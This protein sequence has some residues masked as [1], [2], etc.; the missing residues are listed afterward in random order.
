MLALSLVLVDNVCSEY[1][2]IVRFFEAISSDDDR[3]LD[4]RPVGETPGVAS[5]DSASAVEED[6]VEAS[7]VQL[8]RHEQAQ[9]RGRG[10]SEE[11]FR[12][13]MEPAVTTWTTFVKSLLPSSSLTASAYFALLSMVQLNDALLALV[14]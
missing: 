7:V 6:E 14:A 9:L 4:P 11:V 13:I 3:L 5:V 8:S 1:T 10:A 12:Q 2:F